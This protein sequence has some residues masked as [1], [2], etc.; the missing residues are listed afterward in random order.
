MSENQEWSNIILYLPKTTCF[1]S[2]KSHLAQVIKNCKHKKIIE[3][4]KIIYHVNVN[5]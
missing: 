1:P 3:K 5:L 4:F 2:K